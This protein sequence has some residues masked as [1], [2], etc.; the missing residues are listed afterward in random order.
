VRHRYKARPGI[1]Q[2]GPFVRHIEPAFGASTVP[3]RVEQQCREKCVCPSRNL[4]ASDA[5]GSDT[6]AEKALAASCVS[7]VHR[8]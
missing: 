5:I 6:G 4:F 3:V 7:D 8:L 1:L 2:I